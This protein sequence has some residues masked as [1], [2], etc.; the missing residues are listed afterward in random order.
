MTNDIDTVMVIDEIIRKMNKLKNTFDALGFLCVDHDLP[1]LYIVE[2][3]QAVDCCINDIGGN[4]I[5]RKCDVEGCP[6]KGTESFGDIDQKKMYC[7][8]HSGMIE[9]AAEADDSY[10]N[11]S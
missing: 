2:A 4:K 6:N 7:A 9:Q 8:Q 10:E 11:N 5:T 3:K 1:V